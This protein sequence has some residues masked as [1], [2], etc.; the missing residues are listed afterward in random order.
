MKI[1]DL[2]KKDF[3]N[4]LENYNIGKYNSSKHIP[5]ALENTVYILKTTKGKFVLKVFEES[6]IKFMALSQFLNWI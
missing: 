5:W 6:D 2:S 3:E 4:I 1:T